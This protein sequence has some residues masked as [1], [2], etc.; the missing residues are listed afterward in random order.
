MGNGSSSYSATERVLHLRQRLLDAPRGRLAV[1][2]FARS[3]AVHRRTVL[4]WADLLDSLGASDPEAPRVVRERDDAGRVWIRLEPVA[5]PPSR[6][7]Y[8]VA[9]A[10]LAVRVLAGAD[11][12]LLSDC[13]AD[14]LPRIGD[15]GE[16]QLY[17]QP[18]DPRRYRE[19]DDVMDV[20]LRAVMGKRVLVVRRLGRPPR[21]FEPWTLVAY[22]EAF[23]LYGRDP[24][25]DVMRTLAV[26]R[27]EE[28][29]LQGERFSLPD[30]YEPSRVFG[31]RFGIWVEAGCQAKLEARF[32][33]RVWPSIEARALP[34]EAELDR[35]ARLLSWTVVV[36]PE[37]ETWLV[38]WGAEVEVLAPDWLRA[39]VADAHRA[40]WSLYER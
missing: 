7:R 2:D 38:S 1:D 26:E 39:R 16:R 18:H 9:G 17:A 24:D 33:R 31:G 13:A 28:A 15:L 25:L 32:S 8:Q 11:G 6:T 19:N 23:Y 35:D 21:R 36:T 37:V 27:I 14:S 40:A 34:G 20:V 3:M 10:H 4:R 5:A 12:S 30:D 22:R 29:C